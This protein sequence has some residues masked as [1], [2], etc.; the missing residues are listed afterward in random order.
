MSRHIDFVGAE[1][2]LDGASIDGDEA[3]LHARVRALAVALIV[4]ERELRKTAGHLAPAGRNR[5][6]V[7]R[8]LRRIFGDPHYDI[9]LKSTAD[10]ICDTLAIYGPRADTLPKPSEQ[11]GAA[12]DA[13]GGAAA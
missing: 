3:H 2:R 9:E 11:L 12:H 13:A 7:A 5:R 10:R 1:A 6:R 8:L 4:A